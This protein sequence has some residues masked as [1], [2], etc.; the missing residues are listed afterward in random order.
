MDAQSKFY[1]H[2]SY[3]S[4]PDGYRQP[5]DFF[6]LEAA[7]ISARRR[8]LHELLDIGRLLAKLPPEHRLNPDRDD[9]ED[10]LNER[11]G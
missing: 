11:L 10:F 8:L 4:G 9:L 3:L 5:E 6:D 1:T 2:Y 7:G